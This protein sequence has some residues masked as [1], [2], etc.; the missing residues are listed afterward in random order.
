MAFYKFNHRLILFPLRGYNE[1][2]VQNMQLDPR[3]LVSVSSLHVYG[4]EDEFV[5]Q[6]EERCWAHFD[7]D[8][9]YLTSLG[10]CFQIWYISVHN[11]II[12]AK[13]TVWLANY[14]N[15]H[16]DSNSISTTSPLHWTLGGTQITIRGLASGAR[17]CDK[18]IPG[19]VWGGANAEVP[20]RIRE[21]CC[22]SFSSNI[23]QCLFQTAVS[24]PVCRFQVFF[25]QA[26]HV[27]LHTM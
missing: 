18:H 17:T 16:I 25:A 14:I 20:K 27:Q 4:Q 22:S 1:E 11:L 12:V 7:E 26:V 5:A 10:E 19:P 15:N 3:E 2:L 21:G 13:I 9:M 23:W 6:T 24:V 8:P